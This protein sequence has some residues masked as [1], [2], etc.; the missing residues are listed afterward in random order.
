M[1]NDPRIFR[2]R[3]I[4]ERPQA[5]HIEE[6]VEHELSRLQLDTVIQRGQSVAIT[7]GSRGIANIVSILQAVVQH[8]KKLHA[9]PFI[10]PAMGS[11]G[12]AT[13]DGQ[14]RVLTTYGITESACGCPIRS[15]METVTLCQA[16]EGFPVYMDRIA[17]QA[18]HLIVVG[19]IK[20]HT[21]FA[22]DIESGLAKMMLIG[23]GK[24][25]G[26]LVYH[27]AIQDYSFDQI[28]RS[29]AAEVLQRGHVV[30]GLAILE[31]AYDETAKIEAV[32]P[33]DF[34]RREPELLRLARNWMPQLPFRYADILLLDQIGKDIS[35]AGL[36]TNVVGRK[37]LDHAARADE[38]PRIHHIVVRGLSA[39]TQGNATG[40]GL[41]EFCRTQVV[42]EINV[43]VTRT[44]ALTG[45]HPIAAMLPLDYETDQE[46]LDTVLT[47]V[48]L[49]QPMDA[50]IV[51]IADTLHLAEIEC[52]EAYWS[53][54][55]ARSD[56]EVLTKPRKLPIGPDG[57]LPSI[58]SLGGCR[59]DA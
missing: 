34:L 58:K 20:P 46:I 54:A 42:R 45:G 13:A 47:Q 27:R 28:V 35:G 33:V 38:F 4:F 50:K 10:V 5:S 11:H 41:V 44:N 8:L 53:E 40:I 9:E 1:R 43:Q 15:G 30:A 29:V 21:R 49:T 36:D 14:K 17:H 59:C 26:A 39:A 37:F 23:L 2:V 51:W 19:R 31:N 18:D 48:G 32:K 16:A 24:H 6:T 12:G 55:T 3:Q 57:N 56:L 25:A 7:A 52:S 22:G